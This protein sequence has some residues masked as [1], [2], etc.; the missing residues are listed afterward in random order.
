MSFPHLLYRIA[1]GFD[2]KVPGLAALMKKNETVLMHKLNPHKDSHGINAPE[3]EMMLDFTPAG[4]LQAAEFFAA[5]CNSMVLPL[6]DDKCSD[7]ALLDSYVKVISELGEFSAEFQKAI[8]D[9]RI[10]KAEFKRLKK[11]SSDVQMRMASLIDRISHMVE[12]GK[13]G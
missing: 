3:I 4:N 5:K 8:A 2:G 13:Y 12:G 6:L 10:T 9:G 1:H 11:E 7:M